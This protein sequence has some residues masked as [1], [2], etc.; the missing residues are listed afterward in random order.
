M[1]IKKCSRALTTLCVT[2]MSGRDYV[3][4]DSLQSK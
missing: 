1:L 3:Y 2:V 4:D